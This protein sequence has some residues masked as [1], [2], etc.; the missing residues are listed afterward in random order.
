MKNL[1]YGIIGNC[2]SA[3][4]ISETGA[5]DWCCI[6]DFDSPSIFARLLDDE[7]GGTFEILVKDSYEITQKYVRNTNILCTRFASD[8]GIFEIHDFMPRYWAINSGY[9]NPPEIIRY[10][11]HIEG[12][13]VF[14]INY[15]PK[16]EYAR[17]ETVTKIKPEY[18][19]SYTKNGD[20]DSLYL[21]TNLDKNKIM[22]QSEIHLEKD[23]FALMNYNQKL[24]PQT[25]DGQ[26]LKLNRTKV[27]WLD[28]ANKITTFARYQEPIVRSTL[29]LKLLTYHKTGAVLAAATTSLPE[30]IGEQ[31]NW[32]Y[33]FCWIRDASMAINVMT[34]LGHKN[35][36]KRFIKFI[37]DIIP[38][39]NEKIQIMY[40][41]NR[42]KVLTEEILDHL[43]GYEN[44]RPVRIGNAAY[45]QRQNDI[46]G[47]L[48]DV[49]YQQFKLFK[50]SLET[51][52]DLWTITRSIVKIVTKNWRKPDKSIWEIR[53]EEKHFTFSK[54][55]C[56]VAIDRA[57]KIANL[58]E[59]HSYA[60]NW[61]PIASE[62]RQ[63]IYDNAWNEKTKS[64]TQF[65]GSDNQDAANLLMHPYGFLAAKEERYVQTV[66]AIEKDLFQDGLMF[67]YRNKDDFGLPGSSF[68]ICTFWLI[69]SLFAIGEKERAKM[70]F[71]KM[72]S[73][74]NHLGLFSEDLDFKTKRLLGNFPQAY[75]HL[76]LIETAIKLAEG[77]VSEDEKVMGT[78]L[79][80]N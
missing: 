17:H 69:E 57:I 23:A 54:V 16:L 26:Y 53:T 65:Y 41:I 4:L 20:Y 77:N 1:N 33:R 19:K 48:M 70:M 9:Y 35:T 30:T 7:I 78:I 46:Y 3:A 80:Q 66:R 61:Q 55:L 62:I 10:F 43:K 51:G 63:D 64:Y 27:Y 59:K 18:I 22:D 36:V 5:I 75:S 58:L 56:W 79:Q 60:E 52:E 71:E 44:S 73:Y 29:V 68:T 24:L 6:P 34:K 39:K 40:G 42:E 67:R 25:L 12:K 28:W 32:D 11:K 21:Y 37:I 47:I 14:A 72:L 45:T 8:E 31:R 74:S 76:A 38:D 13:P 50:T 49:I 2:R 15:D